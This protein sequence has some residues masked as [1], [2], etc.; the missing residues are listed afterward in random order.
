MFM[1]H[2]SLQ[3]FRLSTTCYLSM[4]AI[5]LGVF[6]KLLYALFFN[7]SKQSVVNRT[8]PYHHGSAI[9]VG[10]F[11]ICNILNFALCPQQ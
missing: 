1:A 6:E 2:N 4:V 11:F 7:Y 5:Q 3:Q 8:Y 10:G 9:G